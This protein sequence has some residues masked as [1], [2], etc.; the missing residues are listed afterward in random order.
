MASTD[1]L[2][3]EVVYVESD[4]DTDHDGRADRLKTI[5]IRPQAT[6]QGIQVPVVFTASPYNQG[7][8]DAAGD[9]MMHDVN[10]PLTKKPVQALTYTD[11]A[12]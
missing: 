3:R 5:I 11:I 9:R 4:L 2:V 6:N 7:T 8:N 1:N 12:Y 10:V